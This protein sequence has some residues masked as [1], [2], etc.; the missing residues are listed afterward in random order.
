MQNQTYNNIDIDE[1]LTLYISGEI[2]KESFRI[3]RSFV[4]E[5]D[6]NRLYVQNYLEIWFSSGA[7][8]DNSMFDK[9]KGFENFIYRI[10]ASEHEKKRIKRFSWNMMYRVAAVILIIM[11]PLLGYWK[12]EQT[13][14]STFS[15]IVIETLSG[16]RTKT[17]LPD[18]S[19]VWL[20]AGSTLTYSQGYGVDERNLKLNGEGYFEVVKNEDLPFVINTKEMNLLVKGTKFNF[21]NYDSDEE[22]IVDLFEGKVELSNEL[23]K[24]SNLFLGPNEKVVLNKQTG[25]WDKYS[26][27]VSNSNIWI[28]NELFFNEELISD[29]ARELSRS[30]N[31]KIKVDES[32]KTERFYGNFKIVDNNIEQ[33]LKEMSLTNR[34]NYRLEKDIYFIYSQQ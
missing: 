31:V 32:L 20:N 3:L 9:D 28:Q 34:I 14:K 16:A 6:E 26:T 18:G 4:E 13:V 19:L 22:V 29:I 15:N 27:D 5:S 21:K 25:K 1:L 10:K 11:L 2:S 7:L 24:G 12:G 30:F 23:K 33:V 17:Y 8:K